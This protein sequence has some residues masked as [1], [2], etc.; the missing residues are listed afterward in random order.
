MQ[1]KQQQELQV[2]HVA[3]ATNSSACA[4]ATAVVCS[5]MVK[6]TNSDTLVGTVLIGA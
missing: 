2:M 4:E 6:A 1:V 5:T 3:V